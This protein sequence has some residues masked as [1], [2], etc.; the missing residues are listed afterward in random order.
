MKT[1]L[2][3]L[4]PTAGG[5]TWG[6]NVEPAYFDQEI[7]SLD[8]GS[9]VIEEMA[10]AAPRATEG[11]LRG[12]LAR[13]LFTGD[14][15][16]KG[17]AALSGGERSRLALA[18]L[19][20]SRANV[21]VLDEP[22]N[23]LDIPSREALERAL[24]EYPGTIITISHDRY[25]L[26]K[27]ATEIL[28]FEGGAATYHMGTYSDYYAMRHRKEP[29]EERAAPKPRAARSRLAPHPEPKQRRRTIEQ[30]ET[31]ISR[32]ESELGELSE[33][34]ANP[35]AHWTAEEYGEIS[36]RQAALNDELEKLY[37]EWEALPPSRANERRS[38]HRSGRA[39]SLSRS[40]S[41]RCWTAARLA[42]TLRSFPTG[43]PLLLAINLSN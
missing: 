18:K 29:V 12:Y 10:V 34:L 33:K 30:I 25:F 35:A 24:S 16:Y 14:D 37:A 7:S 23:H 41:T 6:A 26:D 13:F 27:I 42:R 22:T 20:Y 4:E 9:T 21:L 32:F 17:V 2:G 39:R 5:L 28:H 1:I 3:E 40:G 38:P 19:V 8:P 15:I 11:E 36:N 43:L 31:E